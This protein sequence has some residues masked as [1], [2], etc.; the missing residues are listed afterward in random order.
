MAEQYDRRRFGD[1]TGAGWH[2]P[3]WSRG[4]E[5]STNAPARTLDIQIENE[6]EDGEPAPR[7]LTI[8]RRLS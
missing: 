7:R 8:G 3:W 6:H 2:T 5:G 1:Y 4:N